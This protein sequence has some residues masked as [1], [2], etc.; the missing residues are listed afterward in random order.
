M[1]TVFFSTNVEYLNV[2][3]ELN[4]SQP[5]RNKLILRIIKMWLIISQR[6]K[7]SVQNSTT[8]TARLKGHFSLCH[9]HTNAML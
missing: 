4:F 5:V 2:L 9:F 3:T 6:L 1:S 7:F 8:Y